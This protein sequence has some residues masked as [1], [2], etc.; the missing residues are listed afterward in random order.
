MGTAGIDKD[1]QNIFRTQHGERISKQSIKFHDKFMEVPQIV[2]G[3]SCLD[4]GKGH[5]TRTA[6]SATD[7]TTEGF[8]MVIKTWSDTILFQADVTWVAMGI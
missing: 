4:V 2:V 3:L 6:V 8:T 7:I 5:N 1:M